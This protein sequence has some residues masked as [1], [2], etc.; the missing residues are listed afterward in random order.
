MSR[1]FKKIQQALHEDDRG[2]QFA[3]E[4]EYNDPETNRLIPKAYS[5][6][7]DVDI[8]DLAGVSE[9]E[10]ERF[11]ELLDK[12]HNIREITQK[13]E[14]RKSKAIDMLNALNRAYPEFESNHKDV[15]NSFKDFLAENG[16]DM[17]D[18]AETL[19]EEA[20]RLFDNEVER[21]LSQTLKDRDDNDLRDLKD[22]K[23]QEGKT[24]RT[25]EMLGNFLGMSF[26]ALS[27]LD[28]EQTP[29]NY[30]KVLAAAIQEHVAGYTP[31]EIGIQE[32][33]TGS[34]T[35]NEDEGEAEIEGTDGLGRDVVLYVNTKHDPPYFRFEIPS[36]GNLVKMRFAGTA[37]LNN[38][39]VML[40]HIGTA[41]IQRD[42][43]PQ[44]AIE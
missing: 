38:L 5:G 16:N 1:P 32:W 39:H 3:S 8:S 29:E 22:I 26:S 37:P 24:D 44:D 34:L 41:I 23:A 18:N 21:E 20:E 19:S 14:L 2:T 33:D 30:I 17:S 12:G 27:G 28:P 35:I 15:L 42:Y 4:T 10:L 25:S 9:G 31:T 13:L 43:S 40:Q 7:E 11:K 6:E 36:A